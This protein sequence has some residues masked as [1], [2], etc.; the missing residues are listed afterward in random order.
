MIESN[1]QLLA[2]AVSGEEGR[3]CVYRLHSSKMDWIKISYFG[4]KIFY[5]SN[6]GLWVDT[7]SF[8]GMNNKNRFEKVKVDGRRI[9]IENV[10]FL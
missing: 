5:L 2:V 7:T 3:I 9:K 10:I 8:R 1:G 6:N 4:N